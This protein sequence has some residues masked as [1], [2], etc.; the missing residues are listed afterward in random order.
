MRLPGNWRNYLRS[1]GVKA[2]TLVPVFLED[3]LK[4][5]LR[6]IQVC[7]GGGGAYVPLDAT[8]PA[9]RIRLYLRRYYGFNPHQSLPQ[10]SAI[11]SIYSVGMHCYCLIWDIAVVLSGTQLR[12]SGCESRAWGRLAYVRLCFSFYRTAK[13]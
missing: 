8:Y 5:L 2:D 10:I 6:A 9:E 11:G 1:K 7:D 3:Q 4:W 13:G 12:L